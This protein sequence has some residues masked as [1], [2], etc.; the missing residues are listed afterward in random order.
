SPLD[1]LVNDLDPDDL[2]IL[3]ERFPKEEQWGLLN[4]KGVYPYSYF[5]N[6]DKFLETSLPP[7]ECF[8]NDLN[9]QDVSESDYAR[10]LNVFKM[11][12]MKN[13]W[14]YHDLYLMTDT[15][16][17]ACV[18]ETY[19]KLTLQYFNL[20]VVY[21]YSGPGFCWDAALLFTGQELELLTELSDHMKWEKAIRGGVSSVNCRLIEANNPYVKDTYEPQKDHIYAMHLDANNLYGCAMTRALPVGGFRYL[22]KS[23][24]QELDIMNINDNDDTGYLFEVDLI[25]PSDIH[26]WHNDFP[27]APEHKMIELYD[28]P[29]RAST[30]KL[31]P[32]LYDKERY[33]VYG[34]TLKLYLSLGIE[35]EEIHSV[36]A[37]DQKPWL[38]P[39]INFNTEMRKQATSD[40]QKSLWKLYNNSTFGKTIESVRKRRNVNF[41]KKNDK[42]LKLVRSPLYHSFELF[43]HGLVAVERKKA[44]I[45]LNR[46][47]YT[48]AVILDISKEIMYDFYY[49]CLKRKYGNNVSVGVTDTDS[50]LLSIKTNDVYSDMHDLSDHLDTSDYPPDHPLF[51]VKNKKVL[52]KFKDELNGVPLKAMVGLRAKMYSFQTANTEKCVAKGVP[53]TAVKTQITFQDYKDC[54]INYSS[55]NVT[56]K[57]IGTD[58]K[59]HL[60][61][62]SC[63]KKALSCFDDKRYILDNNIDTLAH[64][65]YK[66]GLKDADEGAENLDLL[67]SLIDEV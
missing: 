37:F 42:F 36:M 45:V 52:G 39:F 43:D 8:R 23:E 66:I 46:P 33:C 10:A 35:L 26:D 34:S 5:C 27:L 11:F 65:H 6:E 18:M 30:K 64:G 38:A 13:L 21:Y 29:K 2:S 62:L 49:N 3:K 19:R 32:N 61:T 24:I 1:K 28:L 44:T 48:G 15:L 31:I 55:K 47:V 54:L 56:F 9:G 14:D 63:S 51:S 16:L 59:H 53:K 41:T 20:D 17:L 58:Q 60:F 22:T 40:F 50:L 4:R 12:N 25:Y 57:K 67:V 7:R